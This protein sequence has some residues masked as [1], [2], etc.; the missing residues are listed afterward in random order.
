MKKT[1]TAGI[2]LAI[3]VAFGGAMFYLYQK[4]NED[5][6]VYE[7]ETASTQ[8]I[9]SKT[10]ATGNILPLEE[11]LIK[12][13]ISGVIEE[14]YVEGGDFVKAGDLLVKIRVVPNLD[15]LNGAK[16]AI[17]QAKIG[18]DDQKR[19]FE[20]QQVLFAKG[21]VSKVDLERAQVA[22]DQ[23]K[24]VYGAANKR[25][26]IVKT[27]T[28]KGFGSAANTLIK[29]T[30]SGMV[31]EVPVEVGNQVIESNTFNEGTT[32]AAIADVEKMI[33]EG[34]VDESEVG[35]IK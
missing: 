15:A 22:F 26:D 17:D 30:V 3:V 23:A 16:D 5:P 25:Y 18:L 35:K 9:V 34:K 20:R 14:I 6:V 31:L 21:V 19:N 10:V 12:P 2:L 13:N 32:I 33:F 4:N 28:T 24:Q 8:T 1:I 11:V 7:T 29:S 27:G